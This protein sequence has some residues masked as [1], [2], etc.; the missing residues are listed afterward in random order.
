VLNEARRQVIGVSFGPNAA[1]GTIDGV[2]FWGGNWY[3]MK[4][5]VLIDQPGLHDIVI[6]NSEFYRTGYG[7]LFNHGAS[8][9]YN[10]LV[11]YNSFNDLW[12]GDAIAVNCPQ[13]SS[14]T[15]ARCSGYST[16]HTFRYNVINNVRSNV[17]AF[18]FGI[19]MAGA[20][21]NIY[22]NDIT[23]V[24]HHGIHIEDASFNVDIKKNKVST[25]Y[26]AFGLWGGEAAA[27]WV[28]GA[29]TIWIHENQIRNAAGSGIS[30]RPMAE[31]S[32]GGCFSIG[33]YDNVST[34]SG[35]GRYSN[36]TGDVSNNHRYAAEKSALCTGVSFTNNTVSGNWLG[37]KNW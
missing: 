27:I 26:D 2:K 28:G 33:I 5:G 15:T 21:G 35:I 37:I 6:K 32:G 16:G 23:N 24:E 10:S 36:G 14:Y 3:L 34:I 13:F 17:L 30:L 29:N 31:I 22:N 18:G 4:M 25:T 1:Y 12:L 11:E 20:S 7:I 8:K 19:S 9:Y